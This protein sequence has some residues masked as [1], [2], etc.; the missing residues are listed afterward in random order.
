MHYSFWRWT[1]ILT[2]LDFDDPKAEANKNKLWWF[3]FYSK[4]AMIVAAALYINSAIIKKL[5]TPPF[6]RNARR[7]S[8]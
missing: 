1:S 5:V 4:A 8:F 2:E 3:R 6:F 7:S